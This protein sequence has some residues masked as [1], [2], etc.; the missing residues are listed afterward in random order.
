MVSVSIVV[1]PPPLSL[2]LKKNVLGNGV[3]S[4]F[5]AFFAQLITILVNLRDKRKLRSQV[6][7]RLRHQGSYARPMRETRCQGH[8][9]GSRLSH[10]C[11]CARPVREARWHLLNSRLCTNVQSRGFVE[12]TVPTAS[13]ESE[14]ESESGSESEGEGET[15]SESE[16]ESETS[17]T[18]S[19]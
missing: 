8:L 13:A 15:E 1:L 2:C 18:E 3:F 10:Q 17:E 12:I 4:K 19:R 6:R 16:S 7:R 11:S 14:S 5:C 9:L